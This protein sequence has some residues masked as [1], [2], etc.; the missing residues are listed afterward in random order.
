MFGVI[1]IELKAKVHYFAFLPG[2]SDL[3][4]AAFFAPLLDG[5]DLAFFAAL[6]A[7]GGLKLTRRIVF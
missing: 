5:A 1:A 3:T 7:E 4:F 6:T 2:G